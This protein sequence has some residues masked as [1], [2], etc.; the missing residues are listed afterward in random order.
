MARKLTLQEMVEIGEIWYQRMHGL[1]E[2]WQ[3]DG[4]PINRRFKAYGLWT[5]MYQRVLK[6]ST[7][8]TKANQPR[9]PEGKFKPGGIFVKK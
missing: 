7:A 5:V 1:R 4:N 9:F 8:I 3:N 6:I 2:Y